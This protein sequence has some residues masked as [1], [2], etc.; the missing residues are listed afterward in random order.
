MSAIGILR[1][2]SSSNPTL[3]QCS[4]LSAI[5]TFHIITWK[6]NGHTAQWAVPSNTVTLATLG[7][8][9]G[10]GACEGQIEIYYDHIHLR[11]KFKI[12]KCN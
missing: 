6:Q 3:K 7:A 12:F 5:I 8:G 9:R 11:N 2:Y 4:P 10:R 1:I